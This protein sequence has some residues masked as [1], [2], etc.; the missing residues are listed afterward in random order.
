[1]DGLH[2][3]AFHSTAWSEFTVTELTPPVRGKTSTRQTTRRI[4]ASEKATTL[5]ARK[6]DCSNADSRL[7]VVLSNVGMIRV[8][9]LS[10]LSKLFEE[11]FKTM[12]KTEHKVSLTTVFLEN[13]SMNSSNFYCTIKVFFY[14]PLEI[15]KCC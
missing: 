9:L 14:N 6:V 2:L 5:Q 11:L 4:V 10:K 13:L 8:S 12:A 7:L 3:I 15:G 1:L